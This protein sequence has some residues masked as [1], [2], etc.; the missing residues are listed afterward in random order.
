M[1]GLSIEEQLK[2]IPKYAKTNID[3]FPQ[4]KIRFIK[5]SREFCLKHKKVFQ[6]YI[7]KLS[8]FSLSHQKLEW[9]IKENDSRKLHD[10]IIQ[11]RPSCIRVSKKNRFPSLVS[12]NLTQIPIVSDD[13]KTFRYITTNE[14]LALQSFPSNFNLPEDYSKAFKSLGNAVNVEIVYQIMKYITT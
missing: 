2:L 3:K 10:Y 14:A 7:N 8:G 13:G 11:F 12:I 1:K 9:N 6:I 4:W 5:N